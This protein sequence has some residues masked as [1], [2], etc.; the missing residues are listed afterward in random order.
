MVINYDLPVEAENYVHR[1]GRTARGGKT[2]RAATLASEQDVYELPAIERYVGKKIPSEIA[3][4][5]LHAEDKSAGQQIRTEYYEDRHEERHSHSGARPRKSGPSRYGDN[6]HGDNRHGGHREGTQDKRRA[7]AANDTA[8]AGRNSAAKEGA[9]SKG[10]A[11]S[12]GS[13]MRRP[14]HRHG[15]QQNAAPAVTS[16][17]APLFESQ[18]LSRMSFEERMAVYKKK[19]NS[20]AHTP[21]QKTSKP[22]TLETPQQQS[23]SPVKKGIFSR[24]LGKLKKNSE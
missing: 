2:G 14:V 12:R 15:Q 16:P 17:N 4:P 18:E 23:E 9:V 13:A 10:N 7:G 8:P 22:E 21:Q 1:I 3:A 6:R 19:Y 20:P 11:A 5:E 24:L